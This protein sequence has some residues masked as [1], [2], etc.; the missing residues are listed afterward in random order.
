[1]RYL[2]KRKDSMRRYNS[3]KEMKEELK[4]YSKRTGLQYKTWDVKKA[5]I[6]Q[7]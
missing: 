4:E 5:I 6:M 2:N 3:S 1:M 7:K